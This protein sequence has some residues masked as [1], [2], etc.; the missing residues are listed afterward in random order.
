MH[1]STANVTEGVTKRICRGSHTAHTHAQTCTRHACTRGHTHT[2]HMHKRMRTYTHTNKHKHCTPFPTAHAVQGH[3]G[4]TL[5]ITYNAPTQ[6]THNAQTR[7][8]THARTHAHA[9]TAHNMH[10]QRTRTRT[11]TH[12]HMNKCKHHP[13]PS[14]SVWSS[15]ACAC[16]L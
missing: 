8:Q 10:T 5:Q 15:K 4:S 2:M 13:A 3:K 6:H 14:P 12:T 7:T 9:N 11:H 1:A 16:W